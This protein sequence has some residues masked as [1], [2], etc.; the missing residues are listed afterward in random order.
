MLKAA[1]ND[2]P[3]SLMQANSKSATFNV[4]GGTITQW[5]APTDKGEDLDYARQLINGA[6][7]CILFLFFS[8]GAFR[9]G[10]QAGAVDTLAENI[11]ARHQQGSTKLQS[12]SCIS[13]ASSIRRDCRPHLPRAPESAS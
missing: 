9:A 8:P 1:G 6:E 10:R 7:Q 2:Y 4:D 12:R 11:L 3:A 5:F 13:T